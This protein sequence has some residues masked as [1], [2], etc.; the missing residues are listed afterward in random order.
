M[1]VETQNA[2]GGCKSRRVDWFA[3][4][5]CLGA[6]I[7][8]FARHFWI[9]D[10]IANL[11]VQ[12]ILGLLGTLVILLLLRRWRMVLVLTAVTIWQASWLFSAFPA[13]RGSTQL[14]EQRNVLTPA[15]N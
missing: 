1:A 2:I 9:A 14:S 13:S 15:V 7:T 8:L 10:M 3:G 5:V 4:V 11:R 12:L 6:G